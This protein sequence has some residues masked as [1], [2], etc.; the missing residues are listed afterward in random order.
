M[1][2]AHLC[3]S[4]HKPHNIQHSIRTQ[5]Y[6]LGALSAVLRDAAPGDFYILIREFLRYSKEPALVSL[7]EASLPCLPGRTREVA[8]APRRWDRASSALEGNTRWWQ[9][10]TRDLPSIS[11]TFL[12]RMLGFPF[13]LPFFPPSPSP[14]IIISVFFSLS[15]LTRRSEGAEQHHCPRCLRFPPTQADVRPSLQD[16][17]H[18]SL[19]S[20]LLISKTFCFSFFPSAGEISET[21]PGSHL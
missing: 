15:S 11:C 17:M 6:F 4:A 20:T 3:I 19:P 13:F 16:L 7:P 12:H 21:K 18:C 5:F 9:G 14:T 8:A 1:R 10:H 2:S